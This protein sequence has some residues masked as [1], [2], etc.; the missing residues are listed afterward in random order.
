MDMKILLCFYP[1]FVKYNH[2]IALLS[3]LCKKRGIDVD[4][5]LLGS[6]ED[7]AGCLQNGEF[8]YIGFSFVT[9]HDYAKSLPFVK[10]AKMTG[11]KILYGGVYAR[12]GLVDD[13]LADYICRGEG[14]TLPNFL[15]DGNGALFVERL[16]GSDLN[17]LPLPDY[18]LFSGI[19]FDRGVPFLKDKK[20]LPYY[21]SRGCPYQCSF[22]LVQQ[23]KQKLMFR[24]KVK[25]DLAYL[26]EKY[27]PDAFFI[28]DELL[29]Y[30]NR[31]WSYSW[32]DF[33]YPFFAYIRADIEPEQLNWL[34]DHGINGCAFGVESGDEKHRNE[35]LKKNLT[36]FQIYR[37]VE[38]LNKHSIPFVPFY[39]THTPG[40][41]FRIR[42]KT[43]QMSEQL[44]G[45]P[46]IFE[47]EDLAGG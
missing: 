3:S 8:E 10:M 27:S 18:E 2:G 42:H 12:N 35:F 39:M 26:A 4:L 46:L 16:P 32:G 22:C 6:Y 20:V 9:V 19:P 37:T 34:I 1:L 7:F 23:Q 17:N 24:L 28:G 33:S 41:T 15:L 11:A 47:Y 43:Y 38:M 36:D 40:E 29:P 45:L 31:L 30:Y 44:G 21:T 13:G 14:E 5:Y 25:D